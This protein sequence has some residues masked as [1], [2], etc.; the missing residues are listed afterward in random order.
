MQETIKVDGDLLTTVELESLAKAMEALEQRL[1]DTDQVAIVERKKT[2]E[3]ISV[4]FATRRVK[5]LVGEAAN[6]PLPSEK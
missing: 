5:R 4:P 3:S 6:V 1:T 2:L